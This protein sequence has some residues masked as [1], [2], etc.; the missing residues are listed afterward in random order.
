MYAQLG[1]F[2]I[3]WD[4][5]RAHSRKR[6][7]TEWWVEIS[8]SMLRQNWKRQLYLH[9]R[10]RC[11]YNQSLSEDFESHECQRNLPIPRK[12]ECHYSLWESRIL[13]SIEIV[14]RYLQLEIEDHINH[15]KRSTVYHNFYTFLQKA[16]CVESVLSTFQGAMDVI[17]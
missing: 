12:N 8:W 2:V 10:N 11:D 14:S 4:G 3:M 6:N 16:F 13:P 5:N 15:K 9:L 7:L 17:P 1:L